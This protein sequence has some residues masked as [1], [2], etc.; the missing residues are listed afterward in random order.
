[1]F[2]S[3]FQYYRY[4]LTYFFLNTEF[5]F[6]VI[7]K[8]TRQLLRTLLLRTGRFVWPVRKII[9]IYHIVKTTTT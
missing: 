4:L 8:R 9:I 7:I 2:Y 6:H 3:S 5:S 1:M